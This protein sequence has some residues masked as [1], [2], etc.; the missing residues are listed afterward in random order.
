MAR[1]M[2]DFSDFFQEKDI[3]KWNLEK[4][5]VT[6]VGLSYRRI[7]IN[8]IEKYEYIIDYYNLNKDDILA[9]SSYES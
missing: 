8:N 9:Y 2:P 1:H 7:T 5:L 4:M 3:S 6:C